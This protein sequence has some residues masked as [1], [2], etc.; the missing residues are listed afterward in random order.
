M[1]KLIL[2]LISL[3]FAPFIFAQTANLGKYKLKANLVSLHKVKIA[4]KGA[5]RITKDSTIAK[6]D[7]PTFAKLV[8]TEFKNGTIEVKVLSRLLKTAP[9]FARGFIGVAYRIN[10]DNSSYESI[11][12]RPT[13]ARSEDQVR[14]NH[15]IQ[16]Y[17]YP[18]YKFDRLRKDA[19]EQYESYSDMELDKWITLRIEVAQNQAKLYLDNREH[20]S[21][22]INTP[23]NV[24]PKSG[25]IGLWVDIG[26][27]GYF[28]DL[29]IVKKD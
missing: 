26:T 16:Y 22:F 19:P 12:L 7:E 23:K 5:V 21:I 10:D 13:N 6:F 3:S 8:G 15:S 25:G 11:Y 20:A 27:E 28:T 18:D 4:G 2:I 17:A 24:I 9:E 1:K 14:R 29:K